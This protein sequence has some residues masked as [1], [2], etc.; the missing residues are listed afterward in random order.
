VESGR[1]QIEVLGLQRRCM[2]SAKLLRLREVALKLCLDPLK[3]LLGSIASNGG[4]S[5]LCGGYLHVLEFGAC[6]MKF[7]NHG[8]LFIG[9]FR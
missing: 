1:R 4:E 7:D 3:L 9:L 8:P 5:S 6:R 2:T